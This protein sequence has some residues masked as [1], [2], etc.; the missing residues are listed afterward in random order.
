MKK[1]NTKKTMLKKQTSNNLLK[2]YLATFFNDLE[3]LAKIFY[4]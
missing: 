2:N 4:A 1:K 3:P